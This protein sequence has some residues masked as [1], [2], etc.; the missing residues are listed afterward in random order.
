[1]APPSRQSAFHL[2]PFLCNL[3]L[4]DKISV[5]KR[6]EESLKRRLCR[7]GRGV[8]QHTNPNL[9]YTH[10][11]LVPFA[12]SR[13]W[14]TPPSTPP[15][16][17]PHPHRQ[18]CTLTHHVIDDI[19]PF[20]NQ[21]VR[22]FCKNPPSPPSIPPSRPPAPSSRPSDFPLSFPADDV[23]ALPGVNACAGDTR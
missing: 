3:G 21:E 7:G 16:P 2:L 19:N 4:V 20:P 12:C 22:P 8:F 6:L 5:R 13:G 11:S 14:R 23:P 18:P 1:M 15:P 9:S 10:I 17:T